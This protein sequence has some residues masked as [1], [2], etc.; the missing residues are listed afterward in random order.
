MNM[1]SS[2]SDKIKKAFNDLLAFK[3]EEDELK[4]DA[5]MLS[6][7]FISEINKVMEAQ[8]VQINKTGLA[9]A[10]STSK[11]YITQLFRGDKLINMLTLAKVQK[12][13]NLKFKIVAISNDKSQNV[14]TNSIRVS[15]KNEVD[16]IESG[17][18]KTK[19]IP[20]GASSPTSVSSQGF[21]PISNIK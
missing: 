2:N 15:V 20:L 14:T 12:A 7:Q 10:L 21:V 9:K 4:H 3:S 11:S 19:L 17:Y 1:K 13:L 6:F 18:E 5:H 16:I 8:E